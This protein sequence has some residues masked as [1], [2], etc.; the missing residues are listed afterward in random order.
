M[1]PEDPRRSCAHWMTTQTSGLFAFVLF[2][3]FLHSPS[4]ISL[5]LYAAEEMNPPSESFLNVSAVVMSV[6]TISLAA[7]SAYL[8]I[9]GFIMEPLALFPVVAC[10][11]GVFIHCISDSIS[12]AS[13]RASR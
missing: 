5:M 13:Q 1:N 11:A 10:N 7:L 8:D 4:L 2:A 6:M 3:I 12:N 9:T